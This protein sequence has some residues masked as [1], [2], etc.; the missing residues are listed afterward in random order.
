MGQGPDKISLTPGAQLDRWKTFLA[1]WETALKEKKETLVL[2]DVNID[3]LCCVSEDAP[4]CP[5]LV[6]LH[7]SPPWGRVMD[8]ADPG[9]YNSI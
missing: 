3:W 8:L 9:C 2:G 4:A 1:Q 7:D 6:L 5:R